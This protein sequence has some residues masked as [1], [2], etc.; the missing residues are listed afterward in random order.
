MGAFAE[1]G[2]AS[3]WALRQASRKPR[4]TSAVTAI[5]R[6]GKNFRKRFQQRLQNCHRGAR[7]FWKFVRNRRKPRMGRERWEKLTSSILSQL[8]LQPDLGR[9]RLPFGQ[10][11]LFS[12]F[13]G[14]RLDIL[15]KSGNNLYRNKKRSSPTQE[16]EVRQKP[17]GTRL[18]SQNATTLLGGE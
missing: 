4:Q 14:K 17:E 13:F 8:D 9:D 7:N 5:A 18:N 3:R 10:S 11:R 15:R 16:M 12:I 6:S 1:R 2:R